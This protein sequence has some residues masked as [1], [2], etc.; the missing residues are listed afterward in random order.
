MIGSNGAWREPVDELIN[1]VRGGAPWGAD[2]ASE[3]KGLDARE[4]QRR[5]FAFGTANIENAAVTRDMIDDEASKFAH[6]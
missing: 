3:S 6:G 4:A 5:S 1:E 2:F